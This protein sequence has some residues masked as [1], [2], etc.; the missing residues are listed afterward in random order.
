MKKVSVIIPCYNATKWLPQCF[1]SL[2]KQTIRI[3]EIELIFVDDAS[4]DEGKTWALLEEFE[5][6]Y[7]DSVVIVHLE[8]NMRQ[9]GARN[10]GIQYASGEYLA[11]VDADDFVAE[12]W[13]E[14]TYN[15]AVEAQADI[16]QFE[17]NYYTERIGA[18]PAGRKVCAEHIYLRS[19]EERKQFLMAEKI[20]YGCWNKLYRRMMVIDMGVQYAEHLIYEEPLFVYPLLFRANSIVIMDQPYYYYRQN[21]TGTM[22]HDME[23]FQTLMMHAQVQKMVWDF[24]KKT[25][26]FADYYEEIKLY[27][28]HTYFY[29]TLYFAKRR[30]FEFPMEAY[31][32]L[33]LT[34]RQEVPDYTE[35][36]YESLIPL[37]ME[38]YRQEKKGMTKEWLNAYMERI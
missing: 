23:N 13:L 37:Q 22:R 8:V 26:F 7:P 19:I 10:V 9:G 25:M 18:T 15:R 29:E 33:A 28:L 30:R 11:F 27:F 17:Y 1:L 20:T 32:E 14:Q 21:Y 6:A 4:T 38:L 35:S 36:P 16:L 34:V 5:R 2:V 3:E 31:R 24:M 12:Q